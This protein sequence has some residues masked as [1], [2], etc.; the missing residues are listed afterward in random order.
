MV[1][2]FRALP[3]LPLSIQLMQPAPSAFIV[4]SHSAR[5]VIK[6]S[7]TSLFH[8]NKYTQHAWKKN[9]FMRDLVVYQLSSEFYHIFG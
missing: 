5:T 7:H 2:A 6:L 1:N 3:A 9:E 8:E 4:K